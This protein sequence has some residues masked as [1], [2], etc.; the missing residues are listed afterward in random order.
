MA[1][2][3]HQRRDHGPSQE[4]LSLTLDRSCTEIITSS[5]PLTSCG[6]PGCD[7]PALVA[8]WCKLHYSRVQ[9]T[10]Y[11]E[12]RTFAEKFWDR[13]DRSGECW[14]WAGRRTAPGKIGQFTW[15]GHRRAA[16]HV[17][18]MLTY[19]E[20]PMWTHV[21][22]TCGTFD[23]VRPSHLA[24][25]VPKVRQ[26]RTADWPTPANPNELVRCTGCSETKP[27]SEFSPNG[28][29]KRGRQSYCRLCG[30]ERRRIT[31][32]VHPDDARLVCPPG[33]RCEICDGDG[34]ARGLVLDHDHATGRFRGWLC[35]RC[36]S[37][38]GHVGDDRQRLRNAIA[39][40]E[41]RIEARV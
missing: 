16:H 12:L 15:N 7:R 33:Q 2:L 17:A 30:L 40:L 5:E 6:A 37:A 9:R 1:D 27:A 28:H 26:K 19:G 4:G 21:V 18:W 36:N 3:Q 25:R 13:A 11:L 34:G 23:C 10:G 41:R 22:R 32:G 8:G 39:Y 14:R 38:I 24:L 35:H 29:R 31:N 20:L